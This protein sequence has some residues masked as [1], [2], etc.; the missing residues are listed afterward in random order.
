MT[1]RARLLWRAGATAAV[2]ALAWFAAPRVGAVFVGGWS[3]APTCLPGDLVLYRR[4]VPVSEDDVVLVR[5]GDEP[6]FLH[7]VVAVRLD[8]GIRT[9]GDA[10]AE[11]DSDPASRTDVAGV[12][13][14]VVPSGRV[15]HA[16]V[17]GIRWC[18]NHL[19]IANT[20]R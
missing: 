6:A 4:G 18:Y 9:Q 8:G 19:P 12:A 11:E 2:L 20:R 16:L 5:A 10:N 7:R 1:V 3:M 13:A 15:L 14:A 17:T